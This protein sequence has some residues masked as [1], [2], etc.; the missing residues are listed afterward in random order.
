MMLPTLIVLLSLA[1]SVLASESADNVAKELSREV[2]EEFSGR[3]YR[4]ELE[5]LK[6]QFSST[7][8]RNDTLI[9]IPNE[10]NINHN[11]T[12]FEGDIHLTP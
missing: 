6:K 3:D 8:P 1:V 7:H 11:H 12:L 5:F 2:Q 4:D 10:L 9:R